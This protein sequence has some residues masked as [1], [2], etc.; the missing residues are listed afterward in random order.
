MSWGDLRLSYT[1]QYEE[2]EKGV[3]G[4]YAAQCGREGGCSVGGSVV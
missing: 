1:F 2:V 3:G 4:G